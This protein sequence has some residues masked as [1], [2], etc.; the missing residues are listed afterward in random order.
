I[1]SQV[2]IIPTGDLTGLTFSWSPTEPLDDPSSPSQSFTFTEP[3]TFMVTIMDENTGC[4][5][6]RTVEVG[7]R[8]EPEA[9]FDFATGCDQGLTVNFTDTSVDP[10]TYLWEFGDPTTTT[11]ESTLPS[12]SYTYPAAGTYMVKLTVTS[13]DG[14]TSVIIREVVVEDVPLIADFTASYNSCT[15]E[16]VEVQFTNTSIN[17]A[18]NTTSYSWT[19]SNGNGTSDEENP[20]VIINGNQTFTATLTITTADGCTATSAPQD[21]TVNLGPQEDQFPDVVLVCPGDSVQINPGGAAGFTYAWSPS[22]GISDVNSAQPTFFPSS[23][24]QY[25]V[26]VTAEGTDECEV[27]E[28]VNVTVPPTIDLTV[29]GG[30]NFCAPTTDLTASTAVTTTI[31]W[32]D[33]GG[34]SVFVGPVF[35][36][37]LSG[38]DTY[39]VVATDTNGCTE[40]DMVTVSGGLVNI[41]TPDTVAVCLGE[42]I[43]LSVTN[44]DPND[45]LTY[46]WEPANLFAPGTNT[47]QMPDYL[48][49]IGTEDVTVTVTNQFGCSEQQMVHVAV[50]DP[51]I[52]LGFTSEIDCNGGTVTF[53]NTSTN[54]FGYVWDFGDGTG[55]NFEENPVHTYGEAGTYTVTLDIVYDVSCAEPFSMDVMV[56]AP[57]IFAGFEY[58]ITECSAD[59][60]VIQFFDTSTNTLNNTISWDWTFETAEPATSDEQ[61]PTVTVS[62][63]G[64]LVVTLTIGTANN[65]SN[66]AT[67]TLEIDLVDLDIALSDTLVVCLGDSVTLNPDGD[68]SLTYSWTP[69]TGLDDPT[70]TSPVAT[71]LATTT[72]IATAYSTV[73]ADTCFVTDSVVVFVPEEI[74]LELDQEP[75]VVTCGEDVIVTVTANVEV[76]LEWTSALEGPLGNGTSVTINPF[77]ADTI[78]VV[79]TDEFGCMATDTIIV[80]DNGIDFDV[81]PGFGVTACQG[82]D[83]TL[84]VINIDDQDTLTF[85]WSPEEYII[86]PT[87]G[88]SVNI[89]VTEPGTV[90]FTA[91]VTNQHLCVDTV[92]FNVN[93]LEFEG[94]VADTVFAC[95]NEPTPLN[96]GGNPTYTFNW[97]PTDGLDLTNPENPIATLTENQTY[98]VTITDPSTTCSDQDSIVVIVQPD[99]DLQTEGGTQLCEVAPVTLTATTAIPTEIVWTFNGD[100]IGMGN[101]IVVLPPDVDSCFTY[102]AIATDTLTGCSQ[103]SSEEVCLQIFSNELPNDTVF[104]CANE[105]TPINPGG[106]PSLVYTWEPDDEF[107][108]LTEPWNPVVTT[109]MPLTYVVTVADTVFGC[110]VMDTI[111]IALNPELNLDVIP[112]TTTLCAPGD[113][114]LTANTDFPASSIEWFQLPDDTPLGT[115]VSI[116]FTP[117]AGT[118]E[119]YAVATSSDGCTERDTAIIFNYPLDVSITDTL[120][121]CEPVDEVELSVINNAGDQDITVAWDPEGVLTALDELTVM[122]NPNITNTFSVTVTN[123]FGCSEVLTTSVTV[124][125]LMADLEIFAE[126]DTVLLGESTTITVTGC[127]GCDYDWDPPADNS[128]VIEVIPTDINENEYFVTVSLLGCEKDLSIT[129]FGINGVCDVDHVYIP[130]AFTPNNDGSNDVLRLRSSF[131]AELT[132]VDFFI[133]NRWGEEMF[134]TTNP[135]DGWD[136][137]YRGEQLPPD[138]YGFY[139][140]VLCPDGEELVQKGNINLL[141]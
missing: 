140:K 93:V 90:V 103:T 124:I 105:P 118:S 32:F 9:N 58:E 94:E 100:T 51:N 53:T 116:T 113:V 95:Y 52:M 96:P 110:S 87:D 141:R 73:G 57:Q 108:D 71:P 128:P 88:S 31:E 86:G 39:T 13:V 43:M 25:T 20:T 65:C 121:I 77:R 72:Y 1:G 119:A 70:A 136:G 45:T 139:L 126:P 60:A 36:A 49:A 133:Y 112:D 55:P 40:T 125:D 67:E 2:D 29:S 64:P 80:I 16:A 129:V 4:T 24:T 131:L 27:I 42:E 99:I 83:T 84:T 22:T 81:E 62:T 115:G 120:I 21:I 33:E 28:T 106:D 109:D 76:D 66:T 50:I 69:A 89:E 41:T 104:V 14:C 101:S 26:T 132:E 6:V 138:V 75:V 54:A 63:E 122:V 135:F 107:I 79:A 123:Q 78:S 117:P 47:N 137:T 127:V 34:N 130:N 97:S 3:I 30:G 68:P 23:T 5:F 82:V 15:P 46:L 114:T 56:E 12:P 48:E 61:N 111:N 37:T 74:D 59:S 11:D 35:T 92:E 17:G 98:Y 8:V 102:I 18:N 134:R 85:E 38:T 91:I 44:L 10:D 7:G 19:F